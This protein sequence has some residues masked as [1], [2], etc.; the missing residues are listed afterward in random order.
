MTLEELHKIE[1][2]NIYHKKAHNA[3]IKKSNY[4]EARQIYENILKLDPNDNV[5]QFNLDIIKVIT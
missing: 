5:A 4:I 1:L 3:C 2:L